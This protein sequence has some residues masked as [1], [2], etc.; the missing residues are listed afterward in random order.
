[1]KIDKTLISKSIAYGSRYTSTTFN[2]NHKALF[3][4][5]F[6]VSGFSL[7][8]LEEDSF[9]ALLLRIGPGIFC[10]NGIFVRIT[11][12][13]ELNYRVTPTSPKLIV[14][15]TSNNKEDTPVSIDLIDPMSV[16]EEM[17]II[18]YYTPPFKFTEGVSTGVYKDTRKPFYKPASHTAIDEIA[19]DVTSGLRTE[20]NMAFKA[21]ENPTLLSGGASG[22]RLEVSS[23]SLIS[24]SPNLLVFYQGELLEENTHFF[25]ESP[26][27]LIIRGGISLCT[28]SDGARTFEESYTQSFIDIL[29]SEDFYAT[30]KISFNYNEGVSE[31]KFM[32]DR[33]VASQVQEGKLQPIVFARSSAGG[34]TLLS[35][36]R[37]EVASMGTIES[38]KDAIQIK[39]R[40][41]WGHVQSGFVTDNYNGQA[42]TDLFIVFVRGLSNNELLVRV[43][44]DPTTTLTETDYDA[45]LPIV[46]GH[47]KHAELPYSYM[48]T[49]TPYKVES[50]ELQV[51]VDGKLAPS[52]HFIA[53]RLD[54]LSTTTPILNEEGG[55]RYV[56]DKNSSAIEIGTNPI[57]Q[58]REFAHAHETIPFRSINALNFRPSYMLPR[59]K[60]FLYGSRTFAG[61]DD[62]VSKPGIAEA[63]FNVDEERYFDD[64][65]STFEFAD[66]AGTAFNGNYFVTYESLAG[67]GGIST[68]AD[69][70]LFSTLTMSVSMFYDVPLGVGASLENANK[71]N[72][73][74]GSPT[75]E[76]GWYHEGKLAK[77]ANGGYLTNSYG[78]YTANIDKDEYFSE[79]NPIVTYAALDAYLQ[80]WMDCFGFYEAPEAPRVHKRDANVTYDDEG[81]IVKSFSD[82]LT[83]NVTPGE[84]LIQVVNRI[85]DGVAS[86]HQ[87]I[88]TAHGYA[89]GGSF[90]NLTLGAVQ[91]SPGHPLSHFPS[92]PEFEQ[93]VYFGNTGFADPFTRN[94][95]YQSEALKQ[96]FA[97]HPSECHDGIFSIAGAAD[98]AN[99]AHIGFK[100]FT[101]NN[102]VVIISPITWAPE[103]QNFKN[104]YSLGMAQYTFDYTVPL[105]SE[106]ALPVYQPQRRNDH[107]IDEVDHHIGFHVICRTEAGGNLNYGEARHGLVSW[108]AFGPL[109]PTISV[110][111]HTRELDGIQ[112]PDEV[113]YRKDWHDLGS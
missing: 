58:A 31:P 37:V 30:Q 22:Y 108:S 59:T 66:V 97:E 91:R 95:E 18:G 110:H 99:F 55:Q 111:N 40:E 49:T 20:S 43:M 107:S 36:D 29:Y 11:A 73:Y 104:D 15:H 12:D 57:V 19:S 81:T 26:G 68:N 102:I 17:A 69:A 92:V 106:L 5:N 67:I 64:A 39:A 48:A 44:D 4:K 2:E 80:P 13:T 101:I 109:D 54:M 62:A 74:T 76:G 72:Y 35:A 78:V 105:L 93:G 53:N 113:F 8:A 84:S 85:S 3:G 56:Y 27:S 103:G 98:A 79:N 65:A 46:D 86:A 45:L 61:L 60:E 7:L 24:G 82:M 96:Y 10:S 71:L 42:I 6:V 25:I 47:S 28:V 88:G 75:E 9:G 90:V 100:S 38:V 23:I 1:M 70:S 51:F 52:D 89:F 33:R 50:G 32:F 94:E 63:L 16:T 34:Y 87:P 77:D 41:N 21:Y 112:T 83:G 14:G